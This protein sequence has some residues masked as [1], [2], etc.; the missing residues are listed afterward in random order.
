LQPD[1]T[2]VRNP[3]TFI[4]Q[5]VE[6]RQ[7]EHST[8]MQRLASQLGVG[9]K[10]MTLIGRPG[11]RIHFGCSHRIRHTLAPDHS[12]LT[13]A[14]NGDL[15]N[16]WLIALS[17][18]I[19][20][21][22]TWDGLAAAGIAIERTKQFTGEPTTVAVEVVGQLQLIRT[23]SR[24][25]A[26]SPDRSFTRIVFIDAIEPKKDAS[27]KNPFPNTIE[28]S[29]VLTPS[30]IAAVDPN[31]ADRERQTRALRLPV[32]T[33]PAQV[34]K[35]VAAGYALSPY[36]HDGNYA[37]TTVR[38]RF[39]WLEFDQPIE[40]PNDA[41]FARVLGYAPDP[42]LSFLS[43]DPLA[44]TQDDPPLA[45]DPESIRVI[46]HDHGN[47]GAG[48]DAMQQMRAED[49]PPPVPTIKISPVHY[50]LPLPPGL[51]T[52]SLELFGFFVY[53]LRVGHTNAIWS[54]AQ[55]RFGHPI[56]LSGVQHP[57][58]S[59]KCL[60]DRTAD[61]L[62]VTAAHAMAV[63]GGRNVTSQP[64]KTELW[65][66]LYA[67]V[68]QADGIGNRNLLL[69]ETRLDVMR[70]QVPA[71][72]EFLARR[73]ALPPR[74]ANSVAVNLDAPAIGTAHWTQ[75]EI[76]VLLEQYG[77]SADTDL[78]VLAVEMMPRYDRFIVDGPAP[79]TSVRPLSQHLGRYR[80]LRSSPLVAA[81][82]VCCQTA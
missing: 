62:T 54:T 15:V 36:R 33:I 60:V 43:A 32:T 58:P 24:V 4:A 80:I 79:D 35:V 19:D 73:E 45:M 71:I 28:A 5:T 2:Q 82:S 6:G 75:H 57:A 39:L 47:D 63:F 14:A 10:D 37:A 30:F 49:T 44:V 46:T 8:V 1:A 55:G 52:E 42:L 66:M 34:P 78:S 41:C 61:R 50:L 31:A 12:S 38:E 23:A 81:T 27:A 22:W 25:A 20:R 68:S 17:F 3:A 67:Q 77:L 64:P 59:L 7:L 72:R 69:G 9:S 74:V 18:E 53:E 56:R 51:H 11:E 13:F 76:N 16:H 65:V 29:Y 70:Q 40:D 48:L 26:T 21:D